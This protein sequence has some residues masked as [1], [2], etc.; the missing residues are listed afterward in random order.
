[1]SLVKLQT[2]TRGPTDE[3]DRDQSVNT[4]RWDLEQEVQAAAQR[5]I[6]GL[7]IWR[8]KLDDHGVDAA[9]ELL[10]ENGLSASSLSWAGGFTGSDG[11]SFDDAV[12]DALNAVR[13]AELLVPTR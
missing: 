2:R 6:K 4:L 13:D 10:F 7:G 11:R 12:E 9:A 3:E 5:G 8:P 1:M